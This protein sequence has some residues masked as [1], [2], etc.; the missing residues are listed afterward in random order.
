MLKQN[1]GQNHKTFHFSLWVKL[2]GFFSAFH[3]LYIMDKMW[4]HPLTGEGVVVPVRTRGQ[5]LWYSR[6]ICMYFV[7]MHV[8]GGQTDL[9]NILTVGAMDQ[10][11]AQPQV[12]LSL[13]SSNSLKIYAPFCREII[14]VRGQSCVSL[15]QN[16]DPPP[17]SPPGECV[18]P[19]FVGG[20][21][22]GTTV[23]TVLVAVVF[24]SMVKVV[25]YLLAGF[26]YCPA[27][28]IIPVYSCTSGIFS[29]K[30]YFNTF[31]SRGGMH[32]QASYWF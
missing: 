18:P 1:R 19:A 32:S 4:T 2:A 14:T 15:F 29:Q 7:E 21:G 24:S 12:M 28:K 10:T 3:A 26:M 27:L 31:V 8:M 6:Y 16:I 20:G 23:P 30:G 5:T 25:K 22:G 17:P 9:I 11:W 13:W